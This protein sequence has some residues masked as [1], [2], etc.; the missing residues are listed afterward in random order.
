MSAP[1]AAP[2]IN[3]PLTSGASRLAEE[4]EGQRVRCRHPH[5]G[6][7]HWLL[8]LLQRH[9]TMAESLTNGLDARA[10]LRFAEERLAGGDTGPAAEQ[11]A[12]L[13]AAAQRARA[14][15]RDRTAER[16]LAAAILHA[17]GYAL[18]DD[19]LS[20]HTVSAAITPRARDQA[21]ASAAV[22]LTI[23]VSSSTPAAPVGAVNEVSAPP[24]SY[25]PRSR[26]PTPVLEQF[27]RD[28]TRAALEGKLPPLVGRAEE[29]QLVIETLCRRTKRNPVLI[30]PAGVGKTA[31]V[32]GL[33]A[34]I[35]RGEVPPTLAGLRVIAVQPS[36]LVAG[37]SVFGE[38]EKRIKA[39]LAEA[40]QDGVVL[41][42]DEVHSIIGAGGHVGTGDFASLLKP[43]LARGDLACIAATT[44]DE[45]RRFIEPDTALER[46]FQPVRVQELS[47]AQTLEILVTLREEF[48]RGQGVSVPDALLETLVEFA[49]EFLRNRHFP[50]KAV[51][52]LEQVVAHAVTAGKAEVT[53]EDAE[54]VAQ[55]M[56]GMPL[57]L[58]ERLGALRGRLS[59]RA[60]LPEE[61]IETLLSRLEITLRSL[62]LRPSRPSAVLLLV[63][64]AARNCAPLAET[65]AETLFGSTERIVGVDFTRFT[66]PHDVSMLLGAPPG[67]VGYS[68][69]LPLDP[70]TQMPWCVL[71]CEGIDGCH[72][73]VLEVLRQALEDGILTDARG[74][75]TYLSDAVVLLTADIDPQSGRRLGF[76]PQ[77]S[78]PEVD[79]RHAAEESLGRDLVEE[80]DLVC[81]GAPTSGQAQR[82]WLHHRLLTDLAERYRRQGV[83]L[84]W[85][86]TLIDWMLNLEEAGEGRHHWERLI[87]ERLSPVLIRHLPNHV[88]AAGE[89]SEPPTLRI[90][91]E[92]G[93][94]VVERCDA[95]SG[96]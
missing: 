63:G 4:A 89:E 77:D 60:L 90:R 87:D 54:E 45:Y 32:E 93:N 17:A 36:S 66:Q 62:D 26:R 47:A 46:R 20:P 23:P 67:Y 44:D 71:L 48:A 61:Q 3:P 10:T 59:Q 43:A 82:L 65:I 18:L 2:P 42:I 31:I 37:A 1:E 86:E 88:S 15:N 41:F 35:V 21:G 78:A 14:R 22:P 95:G 56:V 40:S 91:A 58:N 12:L 38:V 51:D 76:G 24:D 81:V 30:G 72:P 27:G 52:L 49:Q 50:D 53:R 92:N 84:V 39:V 94:V 11:A 68:E 64:E 33:A 19:P 83:L 5:L 85:D 7:Y 70:V 8:A 55:R 57:A 29:L 75:R 69:R 9:A 74:K 96:A 79:A 73:Q 80:C 25:Q 6:A 16:D 28:L 34:R 13:D